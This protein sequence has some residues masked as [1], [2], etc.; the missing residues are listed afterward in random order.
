MSDRHRTYIQEMMAQKWLTA[1]RYREYQEA[2]D[3][4][5]GHEEMMMFWRDGDSWKIVFG[6][7]HGGE[8][9]GEE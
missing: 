4:K 7:W 2:R 3:C 1:V 8:G 5:R 6:T 9:T